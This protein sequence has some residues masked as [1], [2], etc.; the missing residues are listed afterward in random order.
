MIPGRFHSGAAIANTWTPLVIHGTHPP[1]HDDQLGGVDSAIYDPEGDR[2]I[3][4]INPVAVTAEPV[5]TTEIWE[6]AFGS[7]PEWRKLAELSGTDGAELQ[8]AR[9][10][11]DPTRHRVLLLGGRPQQTGLWSLSL[12]DEPEFTRTSSAPDETHTF[13][14]WN[15]LLFDEQRNRLIEFGGVPRDGESGS[16]SSPALLA[17]GT[18]A[19]PACASSKQNA[20][21]PNPAA[22]RNAAPGKYSV[23]SGPEKRASVWVK[24]NGPMIELRA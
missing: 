6:L 24:T 21:S 4:C 10:A 22:S 12:G 18:S 5:D 19:R 7:E 9:I 23:A 8:D 3:L 14:H 13:Y 15:T 20:T 2:V 1:V 16:D 11:Y 17:L